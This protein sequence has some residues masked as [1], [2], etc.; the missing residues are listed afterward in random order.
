MTIMKKKVSSYVLINSFLIVS[1]LVSFFIAIFSA[2][3]L[4]QNAN[5]VQTI[6]IN[7]VAFYLRFLTIEPRTTI[8]EL[9]F[10]NFGLAL[11]A[12]ILS[13]FSFGILSLGFLCSAFYVAGLVISN[14]FDFLTLVFTGMELVG[15]CLSVFG[16]VYIFDKRRKFH[17]SL[18]NVL[19]F[20]VELV[21]TLLAIYILAACVENQFIQNV[22]KGYRN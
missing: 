4:K 15:M 14:S 21:L 20:S 8:F 17:A 12:Y 5:S 11:V 22:M 13:M 7:S 19:I 10:H 1:A 16:G 9:T 18:K 6:E 3:Q 2:K